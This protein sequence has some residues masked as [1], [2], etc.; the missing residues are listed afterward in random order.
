MG[1]VYP[2]PGSSPDVSLP[3]PIGFPVCAQGVGRVSG[4]SWA[5]QPCL[6]KAALPSA[7]LSSADG[8]CLACVE[9]G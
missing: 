6:R 8:V 2:H 9:S 5:G 7:M 4:S 3:G 1:S